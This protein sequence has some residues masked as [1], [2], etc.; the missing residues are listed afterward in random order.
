MTVSDRVLDYIKRYDMI[1]RGS[2][3]IVGLSG[4]A[5]S[6]CL[7]FLLCEFRRILDFSLKAVHIEHGIR[8]EEALSDQTFCEELCRKLDIDLEV[9]HFDVPKLAK[10]K[11][12]TLE[13][14]GRDIR[15][16][17]FNDQR[18]D[19][20]AVAHHGSDQAETLLFNLF[21]GSALTGMGAMKPVRDKVIRPLLCLTRGEIEAYLKEKNLDYCVDSTNFDNEITRNL[22]RN[23]MIPLSERINPE[24]VRHMDETAEYLREADGFI[25]AEAEKRCEKYILQSGGRVSLKLEGFN[26]EA[27]II[28]DYIIRECI[29]IRA[30]RLKDITA[31]HVS[32]VRKLSENTS[33]KQVS[34][35]YGIRVVRNFDLLD[36]IISD[37]TDS[38]PERRNINIP[39]PEEGQI[40]LPDESVFEFSFDREIP[41][42][43]AKEEHRYTKWFDYDKILNGVCMRPRKAGDVISIKGGNKKIKELFIEEKI[44]AAQRDSIYMLCDG[45]SVIWIPGLRIGEAYKVSENTKKIWKAEK[46]DNG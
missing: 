8:G 5:D 36:L 14:A 37:Q 7:L 16:A 21:R 43:K 40:V 3:V 30:G 38:L 12:L 46:K 19:R 18:A 13:E 2:S 1:P 28:K 20:I 11:G 4:G 15:Y 44:P 17:V 26:T 10:E 6:V 42:E 31:A 33:G 29:R 23:E 41:Y 24:A 25:R 34:L 27:E 9:F 32:A 22:I 39:V 35:P 45:S